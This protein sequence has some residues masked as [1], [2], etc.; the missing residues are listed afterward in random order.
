MPTY[1]VSC[2]AAQIPAKLRPSR[3]HHRAQ[4]FSC[5]PRVSL[6]PGGLPHLLPITVSSPLTSPRGTQPLSRGLLH[7]LGVIA[8]H[9][10]ACPIR[11]QAS[12]MVPSRLLSETSNVRTAPKLPQEAGREPDSALWEALKFISLGRRPGAP[13]AAGRGP[14]KELTCVRGGRALRWVRGGGS[15]SKVSRP[16]GRC[17]SGRG[18]PTVQ[19]SS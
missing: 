8:P 11:L 9:T 13:H 12:G 4:N 19:H 16:A 6:S 5:V 7:R 1:S 3:P 10:R 17:S 14:V 18:L 15:L 2:F